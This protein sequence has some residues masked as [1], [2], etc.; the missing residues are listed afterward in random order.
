MR[1]GSQFGLGSGLAVVALLAG[2]SAASADFDGPKLRGSYAFTGTA[3]CL[4]SPGHVPDTV[5]D[6]NPTPG[7][8]LSNSGFNSRLQP[9]DA[10]PTSGAY[11]HSFSVEGIRK[12]NGN[13]TGTVKGTVVGISHR[14]TPGPNGFPHFPPSA[15][16]AD[17]SFSFTYTVNED[18]SW[19]SAMVPG[20]YTETYTSGPRTGQTATVDAIPPVTGM[21]SQDHKTLVAA[22]VT[23]TVEVHTYSNGDVDPQIC[24]RSRVFIK[25]DGDD[26]DDGRH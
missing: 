10:G 24:H 9:N 6:T 13:G 5:P 23:P 14:P 17:F 21:I 1:S 20:T 22:H 12:F 11:N 16:A 3:D 19:T 25:L 15:S 7:V 4:V 18:G 26:D 8:A 2:V